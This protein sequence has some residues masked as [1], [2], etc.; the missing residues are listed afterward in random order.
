M[1]FFAL[2][3]MPVTHGYDACLAGGAAPKDKTFSFLL[4][5]ISSDKNW[6]MTT[7]ASTTSAAE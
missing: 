4:P 7:T 3:V 2:I 6:Y 5:V 1:A